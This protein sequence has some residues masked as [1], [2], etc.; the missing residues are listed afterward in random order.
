MISKV[1]A[2]KRIDT[3]THQIAAINYML[4]ESINIDRTNALSELY[5]ELSFEKKSLIELISTREDSDC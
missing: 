1:T 3:L 5:R 2:L 4:D